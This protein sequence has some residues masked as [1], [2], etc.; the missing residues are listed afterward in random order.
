MC[1]ETIGLSGIIVFALALTFIVWV[2]YEALMLIWK[3]KFTIIKR[4]IWV[5]ALPERLYQRFSN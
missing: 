2:A 1:G 5:W 4:A 3:D